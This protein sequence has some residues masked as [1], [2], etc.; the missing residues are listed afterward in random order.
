VAPSVRF[1]DLVIFRAGVFFLASDLHLL[2]DQGGKIAANGASG[3]LLLAY[4][5]AGSVRFETISDLE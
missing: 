3:Q 1:R 4:Q 2:T 5:L